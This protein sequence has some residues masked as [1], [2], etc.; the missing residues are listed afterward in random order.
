MKTIKVS[1]VLITHNR[2]KLLERAVE[3]VMKQT[4]SNIELVVV[5]DASSDGTQEYGKKLKK[6]GYK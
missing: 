5:D 1:C 6:C 2:L 3:S 4:Y